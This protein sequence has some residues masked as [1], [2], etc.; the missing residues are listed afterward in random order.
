MKHLKKKLAFLFLIIACFYACEDPDTE[1]T[2][3]YSYKEHLESGEI[4]E[5][6]DEGIM[7]GYQID[8]ILSI[9]PVTIGNDY[10]L[11]YR[12]N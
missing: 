1:C 5:T 12:C 7:C 2:R 8:S 11:Y 4:L 10:R 6:N 9:K 3:C